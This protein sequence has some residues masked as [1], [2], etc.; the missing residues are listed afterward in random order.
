MESPASSEPG[1]HQ[2]LETVLTAEGLNYLGVAAVPEVPGDAEVL[3]TTRYL[4]AQSHGRHGTMSWMA[5]HALLKYD[6]AAAVPGTRSLI[7][8]GLN[9][10]Q[11]RPAGDHQ[12]LVARYAWGKDYHKVL[13]RALQR[14]ADHLQA[15]WPD[16][17]LKCFTDTAPV[18]ERY[19]AARAGGSFT[20]QNTLAINAGLGSWFLLGEIFTDLALPPSEA[21]PHA[22]GSCPSSCRR[23]VRVC[24]TG[25]LG[26]G[27]IDARRCLSYLTIEHEG[28][29]DAELRPSLGGWLFGCDLCQDV[30]PFNLKATT[31]KEPE[32]L[33]WRAGSSLDVGEILDLPDQAAFT[34][35]FGGSPVHRAGFQG[36]RRNA[37]LVAGNLGLSDQETSLGHLA[38]GAD[39]VVAE[40][41]AWALGRIE[42]MRVTR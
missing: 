24:P 35:R 26:D 31:T 21:T 28:P 8:A 10:Y 38:R 20:A 34:R 9:Y 18:D 12:G 41:A 1:I 36:L 32:F 25:A 27:Q 6:P 39:P 15:L 19:W 3:A 37:C 17:K 4:D 14:A 30:C 22:H 5:R 13:L 29:I 42:K 2:I 23:C 11:P 16:A 7:I 40:A 33:A